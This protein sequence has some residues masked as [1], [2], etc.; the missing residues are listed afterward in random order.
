MRISH[1]SMLS[2]DAISLGLAPSRAVGGSPKPK[3][4]TTK[5]KTMQADYVRT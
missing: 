5:E 1:G 3:E 4:N 2:L